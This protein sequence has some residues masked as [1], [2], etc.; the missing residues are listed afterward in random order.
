[1]RKYSVCNPLTE[2]SK[3]SNGL[4]G[5]LLARSLDF[6]KLTINL[7]HLKDL[8]TSFISLKLCFFSVLFGCCFYFFFNFCIFAISFLS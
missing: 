8:E 5:S 3:S 2:L 7:T 4:V 1:M 6:V